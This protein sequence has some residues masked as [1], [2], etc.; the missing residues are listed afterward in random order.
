MRPG[1]SEDG[2]ACALPKGDYELSIEPVQ[3]GKMR[4][5]SLV[6]VGETPTGEQ[7][8]GT[9]SIDMARVGVLER[10]AFLTQFDGDGEA[11]FDWSESATD[12]KSSNWGGFIRH[13]KSGLEAL[14]VNIGS[15]CQCAV[16]LLRSGKRTVGLRVVPQPPPERSGEERG[17][18]YWTWVTVKCSGL[19][20]T[21]DFCDDRDYEPELEEVLDNV[22]FEVSL[23]DEGESLTFLGTKTINPDVPIADYRRRFRGISRISVFSKRRGES[24]KRLSIP[25]SYSVLN[26]G[27]R[28]T[29]RELAEAVLRIFEN[30]RRWA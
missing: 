27:A 10:S 11:L 24:R 4:G 3:H 18:R 5:F 7:T 22:V 28:T 30:A 13:K 9:F 29:S 8:K 21:W 19:A 23:V 15:D 14:Y 1:F 26:L 17:S 16:R 25:S 2:I 12:S 20:N 6:L